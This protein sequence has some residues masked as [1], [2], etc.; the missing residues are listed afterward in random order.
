MY[1]QK[2]GEKMEKDSK[3]CPNCGNK[4]GKEENELLEKVKKTDK[5]V[6]VGVLLA[7]VLV[8][9]LFPTIFGQEY[10]DN[11]L[12]V[13]SRGNWLKLGFRTDGT[14]YKFGEL[15]D[16]ALTSSKW[17]EK[18]NQVIITGKDKETKKKV[19][20]IFEVEDDEVSFV[21]FTFDGEES[22]N[23]YDFYVWLR[24]YI[25]YLPN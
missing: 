16:V 17:T 2:C 23:D 14:N 13:R 25:K 9:L 18:S 3:F 12:T 10:T 6:I 4:T 15:L 5:K 24:D 11:M 1:C 22:T 20:V 21:K 8:I 7:I 19:E